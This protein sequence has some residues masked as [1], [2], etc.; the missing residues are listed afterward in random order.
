[1]YYHDTYNVLGV[2]N[3][4]CSLHVCFEEYH[5]LPQD[6]NSSARVHPA[7]CHSNTGFKFILPRHHDSTSAESDGD[8]DHDTVVV[9]TMGPRC[10]GGGSSGDLHLHA[11]RPVL[12]AH[13]AIPGQS[14]T[15]EWRREEQRHRTHGRFELS[16]PAVHGREKGG[17]EGLD[18][19]RLCC[20]DPK[21]TQEGDLRLPS[22]D[23]SKHC[24]SS[25]VFRND[26]SSCS[27]QTLFHAS[28]SC[29]LGVR[30]SARDLKGV[31]MAG[32]ERGGH[33]KYPT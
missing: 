30:K 25:R 28:S 19:A 32:G 15:C 27:T 6:H 5:H 23:T 24:W 11:R 7:D 10:S 1:M 4:L 18:L 12:F 20:V 3:W 14:T 29:E 21:A 17:K 16:L 13:V 26:R 33:V 8:S 2:Y 31:G 9:V 22:R